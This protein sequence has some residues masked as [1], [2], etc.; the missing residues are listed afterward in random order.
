[1]RRSVRRSRRERCDKRRAITSSA[2]SSPCRRSD[3]ASKRARTSARRSLR[4]SSTTA[5]RGG[6]ACAARSTSTL[7]SAGSCASRASTACVGVGTLAEGTPATGTLLVALGPAATG[8]AASVK[9]L[10]SQRRQSAARHSVSRKESGPR[11]PGDIS[12][13]QSKTRCFASPEMGNVGFEAFLAG[14]SVYLVSSLSGSRAHTAAPPRRARVPTAPLHRSRTSA[15]LRGP[16][17][18]SAWPALR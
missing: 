15:A 5:A 13:V 18:A 6:A 2:S 3:S 17:R 1:V 16:R 10:A 12:L 11:R 14:Q 9:W 4:C 7:V 8:A